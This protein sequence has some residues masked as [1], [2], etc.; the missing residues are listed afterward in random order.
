M[1]PTPDASREPTGLKQRISS[2]KIGTIPQE[3]AYVLEKDSTATHLLTR[4]F[5]LSPD[6]TKF[7]YRARRGGRTTVI[8][9]GQERKTYDNVWGLIFSPDSK[10][11]AFGAED[12]GKKFVVVDGQEGLPYD[13]ITDFTFSPDSKHFAYSARKFGKELI[14]LDGQESK[15]YDIVSPPSFSLNGSQFAYAVKEGEKAFVVLNGQKS[16]SYGGIYLHIGPTFSPDGKRLAYVIGDAFEYIGHR[17]EPSPLNPRVVLD[18]QEGKVYPFGMGSLTFSPDSRQFAYVVSDFDKFP[19]SFV[20]FNGQEGKRYDEIR[21][22]TFSPD[23]TKLAYVGTRR[24]VPTSELPYY[25]P[26]YE[27]AILNGQEGQA[28][29]GGI[30]N[31]TFSPD[32]KQLAYNLLEAGGEFLILNGQKLENRSSLGHRPVFSPDSKH[33][34][35]VSKYDPFRVILDGRQSERY[36]WIFNPLRFSPDGKLLSY[37]VIIGREIWLIVERIE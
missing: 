33:L 36:E 17:E 13:F 20:V 6:G 10:R 8:V 26:Y 24:A 19:R 9:D 12:S 23:S 34:A 30:S 3:D 31:L 7:A 2:Q 4:D 35:Y 14:I 1:L 32:G 37:N 5:I 11:F 28:Y 16:K 27:F 25:G 18:G 29:I 21:G 15:P 22:L